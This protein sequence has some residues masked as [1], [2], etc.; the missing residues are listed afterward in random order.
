[1]EFSENGSIV[2]KSKE[3]KNIFNIIGP[4]LKLP[5]PILSKIC[6]RMIQA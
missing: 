1:M 3:P 6:L 4:S 5:G 2:K